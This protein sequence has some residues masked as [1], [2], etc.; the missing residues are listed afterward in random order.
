MVLAF[1]GTP[2]QSKIAM[3]GLRTAVTGLAVLVSD[4]LCFRYSGGS[5]HRNPTGAIIGGET[6]SHGQKTVVARHCGARQVCASL[7]PHLGK[8]RRGVACLYANT[9]VTMPARGER[10]LL[11]FNAGDRYGERTVGVESAE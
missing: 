4:T 9:V 6:G 3:E 10:R 7:P 8:S 1:F 2:E 5:G 11:T